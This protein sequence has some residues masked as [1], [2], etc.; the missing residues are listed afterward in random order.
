[1]IQNYFKIALRYLQKNRLYAFVNI[2]GLCIGITSCI[3]I[4]LYIWHEQS[5]DR[6]H[7]NADR[8]ARVTWEYNFEDKPEA[9]DLLIRLQQQEQRLVPSS[10]EIFLKYRLMSAL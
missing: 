9:P 6:F 3:L 7:K 5:F 10:K 8:I 2:V 1:M 4:G